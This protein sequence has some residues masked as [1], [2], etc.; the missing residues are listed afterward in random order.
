MRRLVLVLLVILPILP[1]ASLA[2]DSVTLSDLE[3]S[4]WPEFD[5][6]EVLVIYRGLLSSDT[7]LPASVEIAV[8]ARAGQPTAVAYVGEGGQRLN[9]AYT[10]RMEG[11]SLIV[12]FTLET[13]G[14]Q[15]EYYDAL[16]IDATGQRQY[17]FTYI[18]DY[19]LS[20]LNLDFQVP[21]TA[22]GFSLEP[23]ADVSTTESDGLQYQLVN[24]GAMAPNEERTWTFRYQKDSDTLTQDSLAPVVPTTAAPAAPV[25]EQDNSIV[26]I[27]L[28]AFVALVAVGAGAFWLGSRTRPVEEPSPVKQYKRRGSGRGERASA[29]G[30]SLFCHQCG[31]GLRPDSDFCHKC[32]AAVRRS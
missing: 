5:R 25:D 20:S 11:E 8:P 19:G 1:A 10:T 32:G 9:Q 28:V 17:T 15:L 30:G 12:S 16:P 14:F 24:A 26:L 13:L 27:F 23:A 21:P 18:A 22:E 2:Q 31:A 3:I 29:L 7:Q 4:L 6:P